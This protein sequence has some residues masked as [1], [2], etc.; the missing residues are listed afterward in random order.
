MYFL[1]TLQES[2]YDRLI[3]TTT[4]SFANMVKAGNLIDY[5]IKNGRI[6]TQKNSSKPKRGNFSRK[7]KVKPKHC[8][9]RTNP[10][11]PEDTPCTKTTRTINRITQLRVIKHLPWLLITHPLLTKHR[12][13]KHANRLQTISQ[14]LQG[15]IT[16]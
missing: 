8:I 2:Y 15:I 10:I 14:A 16:L 4:R 3:P 7:K 13:Y 5:A 1:N 11:N 6:D 12:P 9:N